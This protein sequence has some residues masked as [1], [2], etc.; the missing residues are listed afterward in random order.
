VWAVICTVTAATP[1]K[2]EADGGEREPV[3]QCLARVDSVDARRE[4]AQR[5]QGG[6]R[7]LATVA[8]TSAEASCA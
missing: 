4:D 2:D 6:E 5:Q 7:E 1:A 3:Q 8:T